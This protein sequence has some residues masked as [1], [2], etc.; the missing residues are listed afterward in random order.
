MSTAVKPEWLK[1][2]LTQNESFTQVRATLKRLKLHTVCEEALCPNRAEC[3]GTGTATVMILGDICTRACRFCA[4]TTGNPKGVVDPEEPYRVAQA[5]YE[6]G[7]KYVVLTSVDR[8]DLPDGGALQFHK[9]IRAIKQLDPTILVEPL[10][11]DFRGNLYALR[12]VIEAGPDVLAHNI[13]TV[14]RL[15]PKVRDRRASYEQSLRVLEAAKE[16]KPDLYTKSSI[17][18]GLGETPEEVVEAMRD[19]RAVGV[20]IVTIGQYLRPTAH[21]RHL[22]VV[23]YVRP[24]MFRYYEEK[25]YELGFRFVASGPLV[26]SSYKAAEAFVQGILRASSC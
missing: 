4:V 6:L 3:W 14:R 7:L 17:M 24:E 19:L 10:I 25:G 5:I 22:P 16:I 8:D 9:T 26:R 1:I 13:E 15:S 23:E 21:K 11:P 18:V 20:D 2:R 12:L